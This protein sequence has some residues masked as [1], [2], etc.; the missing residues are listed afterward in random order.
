MFREV[1]PRYDFLNHLL[2]MS[3]DRYWRWQAVRKAPPPADDGPVLDVC[4]GTADLAISYLRAARRDVQTSPARI[5]EGS[6]AEALDG[7]AAGRGGAGVVAADF[8]HEMLRL[9]QRKAKQIGAGDGLMFVAADT[10]ALPFPSDS[11]QVVSVAFGLRNVADTDRA[12]AEMARVCGKG[13]SVVVLEFSLPGRQPFRAVYRWYLTKV[14]PRIG[15]LLS[16]SRSKAYNYLSASVGEFPSGEMLA[17]RM[18]CAGLAEVTV[19]PL[20]GGI[21]TLYIGLKQA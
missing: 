2:S 8:C 14:L 12:L 16:G 9:G 20:S 11:F 13:G 7:S 6:A 15:Q 5:S 1:A 10:L 18:R 3:V 21:A 19:Q 4:T 17:S